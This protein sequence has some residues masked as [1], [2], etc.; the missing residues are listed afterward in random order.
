[1][2]HDRKYQTPPGL[3]VVTNPEVLK[4]YGWK[5]PYPSYVAAAPKLWEIWLRDAEKRRKAVLS[6]DIGEDLARE[7][8]G[9]T[10]PTTRH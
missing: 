10:N 6:T 5:A 8:D 1:M 4:K 3:V 7:L 9:H 2:P